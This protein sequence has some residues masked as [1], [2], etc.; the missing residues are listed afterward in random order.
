MTANA[1]WAVV[2]VVVVVLM[3]VIVVCGGI[4]KGGEWNRMKKI[5]ID[6]K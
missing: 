3:V 6:G 1:A 2:V 4:K 5:L